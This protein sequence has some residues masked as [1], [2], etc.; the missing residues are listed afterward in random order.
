MDVVKKNVTALRGRIEVESQMGMGTTIRIH[1][2]LTLAIIDGFMVGVGLSTFVIPLNRILECVALPTD[3]QDH[4]YMNL[5]GEVLPLIRLRSLFDINAEP[6][7]RENVVIVEYAGNKA[8]FIVDRLLGEFQTVIKPLSKLFVH[9][10]GVA[11]STILGNGKV[12]LILDVASLV[13][14]VENKRPTGTQSI[15]YSPN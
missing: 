11:G 13:S 6:S 4:E 9:I 14:F 1:L 3:T 5:R 12:A 7:P 8:G 10:K 15:S 2:P